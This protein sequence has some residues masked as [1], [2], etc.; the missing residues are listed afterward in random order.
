MDGLLD[1]QGVAARA[2]E[3][4]IHGGEQRYDP[5]AAGFA[6][7]DHGAAELEARS[8]SGRNAPDPVFTSRT[9]PSSPSA[10]F[11]DMMLAAMSGIDSTV[12]VTSR[13]A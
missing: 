3:W 12:A 9:R 4:A 11:F 2:A 6:Q 7:G 13:S 1:L 5:A 8:S 10:S